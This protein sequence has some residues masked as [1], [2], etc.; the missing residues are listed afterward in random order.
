MLLIA[1]YRENKDLKADSYGFNC[2]D[3]EIE[4]ELLLRTLHLEVEDDEDQTEISF[5]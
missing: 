2:E 4:P 3:H 5:S 1:H